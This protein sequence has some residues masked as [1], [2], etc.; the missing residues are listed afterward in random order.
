MSTEFFELVL[1][2][3]NRRRNRYEEE[4]KK[5]LIIFYPH[6]EGT[7]EPKGEPKPTWNNVYKHLE[8]KYP[9]ISESQ[10]KGYK[11]KLNLPKDP[12]KINEKLKEHDKVKKVIKIRGVYYKGNK[13]NMDENVFLPLVVLEEPVSDSLEDVD[14]SCSFEIRLQLLE[15]IREPDLLHAIYKRVDDEQEEDE[16]KGLRGERVVSSSLID[17]EEDG[18]IDEFLFTGSIHDGENLDFSFNFNKNSSEGYIEVKNW[19]VEGWG[20]NLAQRHV[21]NQINSRFRDDMDYKIVITFG[22]PEKDIEDWLDEDIHHI[23]CGEFIDSEKTLQK[24][25][26]KY[27]ETIKDKLSQII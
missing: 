25:L 13:C 12:K 4:I 10:I 23:N 24:N 7:K 19:N 26:R 2:K 5:E 27:S 15:N 21:E 8:N 18:I 11:Y 6:I 20:S 9:D 17:A 1:N 22:V 3:K 16:I 14:Y